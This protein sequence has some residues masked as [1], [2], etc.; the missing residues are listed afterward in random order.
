[1]HATPSSS[2]AALACATVIIIAST[3]ARADSQLAVGGARATHAHMDL[4]VV[5]PALVKVIALAQQDGVQITA[6]HLRQ[7]FVDVDAAT[8]LQITHN[9]RSGLL[10]S[11][12]IRADWVDHVVTRLLDQQLTLHRESGM[13]H[14]FMR[15][16]ER[17]SVS[18]S[19][20]LYLNARAAQ[21]KHAWPIML[22]FAP[23]RV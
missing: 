5:V 2:L 20:R 9:T 4:R 17:E 16:A 7:G 19:Y 23:G 21:G 15:R 11:A 6:E 10:L 12:H 18:V 1:M 3:P 8:L 13:V 14:V 22:A